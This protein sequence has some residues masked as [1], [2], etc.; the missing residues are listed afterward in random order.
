MERNDILR[1]L[2]VPVNESLWF[3]AVEIGHTLGTLKTPAHGMGSC[4]IREG[5]S[6]VKHW[7]TKEHSQSQSRSKNTIDI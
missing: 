7:G 2:E 4:V 1:R 3:H 5:L 6:S